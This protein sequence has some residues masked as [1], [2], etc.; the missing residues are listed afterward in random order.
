MGE[1]VHNVLEY[2]ECPC[3]HPRRAVMSVVPSGLTGVEM[4]AAWMVRTLASGSGGQPYLHN[5]EV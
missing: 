5:K 3:E 4:L 1:R 2:R